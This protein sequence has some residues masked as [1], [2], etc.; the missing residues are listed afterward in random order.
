M[1]ENLLQEHMA[2]ILR[3]IVILQLEDIVLFSPCY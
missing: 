1:E 3:Y 2:V